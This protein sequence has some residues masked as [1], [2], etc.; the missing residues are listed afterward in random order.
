MPMNFPDESL[1]LTADLWKFRKRQENES[2][3][4]YRR[5]LA[6]HVKPKDRIESFEIRFGVGWNKWTDAQKQEMLHG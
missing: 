1:E 3:V 4:D 2:L 5:A 6:N